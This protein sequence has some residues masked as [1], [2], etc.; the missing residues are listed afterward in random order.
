[1]NKQVITIVLALLLS[2]ASFAQHLIEGHVFYHGKVEYPIQGVLVGLYNQENV[3]I[4]LNETNQDGVF[5]FPNCASGIYTCRATTNISGVDINMDQAYLIWLYD[6]GYLQLNEIELMAAD[7]D[8][9]GTVD[10]DDLNFILTDYFVY[11]Q[12]MPAG[13]WIFTELPINTES[14]GKDGG[15][16]GGSTVG[17][18]QGIWIPTGRDGIATPN[19]LPQSA[20]ELAV[21]ETVRVPVTI[22]DAQNAM[23]GY[24]LVFGFD[25]EIVQVVNVYPADPLAQFAVF[26][27]QIRISCLHTGSASIVD[28]NQVIM[29]VELRLLK[30][31][32]G[33]YQALSVLSSSHVLDLEGKLDKTVVFGLPT[34]KGTSTPSLVSSVFPNPI[35]TTAQLNIES[36]NEATA[37]IIIYDGYGRTVQNQLVFL[38]TGLSSLP[39][40]VEK[41]SSAWYQLVVR[42]PMSHEVLHQ[43]RILKL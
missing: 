5:S 11:N 40:D 31:T 6:E 14:K 19:V 33:T 36:P 29:E 9:S 8:D 18:V 12:P 34:L 41:L 30:A 43:Q 28:A 23:S 15:S 38:K 25:P 27:N 3:L 35:S 16:I 20:M 22:N 2:V 7:V 42:N 37:E 32:N 24:G 17:D 4:A 21:M 1:M 13:T 39:L 26:N 10:S